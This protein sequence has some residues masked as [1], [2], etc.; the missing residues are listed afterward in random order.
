MIVLYRT[1]IH[2]P[3]RVPAP[4]PPRRTF[5]SSP[6]RENPSYF[7]GS[8]D[9]LDILVIGKAGTGKSTL[10]KGLFGKNVEKSVTDLSLPS[11]ASSELSVDGSSVKVTFW[12]S[13]GI[14]NGIS[15]DLNRVEKMKE[16]ISSSDLVLYVLRMDDT[17]LRPEDIKTMQTL[18][19]TFGD[20]LWTRGIVALTF[21]NRV[22]YLDREQVMT[23]SKQHV[24]E[25]RKLWEGHVYENLLEGGISNTIVRRL[26][27]VPVGYYAE[28]KLFPD[29]EP[30]K[31]DFVRQAGLVMHTDAKSVLL[32]LTHVAF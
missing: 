21:A 28:V 6:T 8:E 30:W 24:S 16:Q 32:K 20:D 15:E 5:T 31:N 1:C 3:V 12:T 23:R 14:Y 13:P 4:S 17:R 29:V 9:G 27:V 2:D 25:R 18:S 10:I 19:K 7:R 22:Y 26:S 11:I